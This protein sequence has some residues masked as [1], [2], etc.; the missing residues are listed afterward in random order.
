M[1]FH[2]PEIGVASYFNAYGYNF[3]LMDNRTF[4]T[5]LGES[6]ERHFGDTQLQ[7]L[8]HR[9]QGLDHAFIASGSQFFGGYSHTND[10]DNDPFKD[11]S[12][13]GDHPERFEYFI[14]RLR[15]TG[16]KVVLLSGDRHYAE[17][18]AIHQDVLGYQTYELTSSPVGSLTTPFHDIPNPLRVA[19]NDSAT[20][21]M[22]VEVKELGGGLNMQVSAH[23]V[24]GNVLF[25]GTYTVE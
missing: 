24:G 5:A 12:F 1:N 14:D 15:A 25:R 11:E 6:P 10:D 16:T 21:F 13:Q 8:L 4:R 3:F 7:W 23:S 17:V 18:M 22:L 2:V 20:N 9:L 19:G